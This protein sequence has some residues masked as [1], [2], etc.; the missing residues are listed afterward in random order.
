MKL[1]TLPV[2]ALN[3]SANTDD[4][5]LAPKGGK[6]KEYIPD[7]VI[8]DE[9]AN[10]IQETRVHL[11]IKHPFWGNL[12]CRFKLIDAS[13]WCPTA[14]TDGMNFF[15]NVD[16]IQSLDRQELVFLFAHEIMHCAMGHFIRRDGRQADLW[17]MAA[18]YVINADLVDSDVGKMPTVGLLDQKYLGWASEEVYDELFK[19]ADKI[20]IMM[21]LDMHLDLDGDD[22]D[23]DGDG[24]GDGN[25][26]GEG[27]SG[28]GDDVGQSKKKPKYS[29]EQAQ[30]IHD[31]FRNNII[32][33]SQQS[34]GA[35]NI[36][37]GLRRLIK[38]WTE[39]QLDWREFIEQRI[40]STLKD[41]WTFMKSP[42]RDF[43]GDIIFPGRKNLETI[44][45]YVAVDTSGSMSEQQLKDLMGEIYGIM[46]QF[47]DFVVHVWSFDTQVYNYHKY[48]AHNLEEINDY[49]L[50]G[51][52]GTDFACNWEWMK[53]EDYVPETF[54]LFTDGYPCGSWGDENYCETIFLIHGANDIKAPFGLTLYY[55]KQKKQS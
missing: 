19:N 4:A 41:D 53:D 36:P 14:A 13:A 9:C 17:N 29:K 20:K 35:G 26:Y 31:E 5:I 25:I 48:E 3:M 7:P 12:A 21:P 32:Q 46:Q 28:S 33:A 44:E 15:F 22:D 23:G 49:E 34:G 37:A 10:K 43:P 55:K 42:R 40:Q 8:V 6:N 11:L 16:F 30:A 1:A 27:G 2:T 45:V 39:P 47:S 24:N 54:L 50:K 38:K 51:G 18:D 52:G